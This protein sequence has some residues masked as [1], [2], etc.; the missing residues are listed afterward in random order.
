[1]PNHSICCSLDHCE[2]MPCPVPN[3][4]MC[5]SLLLDFALRQKALLRSLVRRDFVR[6]AAGLLYSSGHLHCCRGPLLRYACLL[7]MS[8]ATTTTTITLTITI[9]ITIT[10]N[11][12][13]QTTNNHQLVCQR[14][15]FLSLL[16]MSFCCLAFVCLLFEVC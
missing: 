2:F 14:L 5:C 8:T 6:P 7:V 1:M 16:L 3:Y 15:M 10:T 12:K 4:S 11:N 9:I 13:Q